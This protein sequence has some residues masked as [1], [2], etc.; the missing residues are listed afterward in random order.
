MYNTVIFLLSFLSINFLVFLPGWFVSK[1]LKNSQTKNTF[2]Q[3][4]KLYYIVIRLIYVRYTEDFFRFV[5][6]IQVLVLLALVLG[7]HQNFFLQLLLV[8]TALFSFIYN[9][10]VL[11]FTKIFK[12]I[13]NLINDIGFIKKGFLFYKKTSVLTLIGVFALLALVLLLNIYLANT[14]LKSMEF[15]RLKW[16]IA[17]LLS[18]GIPSFLISVKR[19]TYDKYHNHVNISI[20]RHLYINIVK[21]IT[22]K[23]SLCKLQQD[24]PYDYTAHIKLIDKPN[25]IIVFL[26]SYGSYALTNEVYGKRLKNKL[27]ILTK[28][29]SDSAWNSVSSL[30]KAPVSGGGSWLS[31]SS[32]IFGTKISD[33]AAHELI[34]TFSDFVSKLISLPKF[35]QSN[36]YVTRLANTLSHEKNEVNWVKLKNTYPFEEIALIDSFNYSGKKI[37][38]GGRFALPDQYALNFSYNSLKNKFPFFLMLNTTNSH[39]NFI[40]PI[41]ALDSWQ[42]YNTQDFALTDGLKKNNLKNYFTAINYQFDYIEK[43]LLRKDLHNTIIILIGDHQPPVITPANVDKFTPIHIFSKNKVFTDT[44]ESL[45]Y[46]QGLV[47]Q[48]KI[49]TRH[50]SFFSKFLFALNKAYGEN[51]NLNLPILENGSQLY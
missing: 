30:S 16:F 5:L 42:D 25:I 6:E 15:I 8:V 32:V 26:E 33:D 41:K 49:T 27:K 45:G 38:L 13:P 14:M 31:H 46:Y 4:N 12:R 47:P 22:L 19:K 36:T 37:S 44:F 29:L 10:Y 50:E 9:A 7:L 24:Y 17:G 3:S 11:I 18:I 34:F 43:F 2:S 23:K 20:I 48:D 21:T 1:F 35:L 39:Y 51:K 28:K 40:S